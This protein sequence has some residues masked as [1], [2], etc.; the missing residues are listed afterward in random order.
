MVSII[1]RFLKC[2]TYT[3]EVIKLFNS[4]VP[5]IDFYL[6]KFISMVVWPS[7][8]RYNDMN[9]KWMLARCHKIFDPDT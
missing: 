3:S 2:D 4:I 1:Y 6:L 7:C 5:H 9:A 8:G